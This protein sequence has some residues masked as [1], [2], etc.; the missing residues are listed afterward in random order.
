VVGQ[1]GRV[2]LLH[3]TT[4]MWVGEG[5]VNKGGHWGSVGWSAG[6]ISCQNQ[7]IDGAKNASGAE[8]PLG[9][10][11]WGHSGWRLGGIRTAQSGPPERRERRVWPARG[12][13]RR[14]RGR[15]SGSRSSTG[16][17]RGARR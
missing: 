9:G 7:P 11:V 2:L 15:R 3:S 5:S 1:E 12:G 13:D 10:R 8:S 17:S 6:R 4:P 14:R 16:L